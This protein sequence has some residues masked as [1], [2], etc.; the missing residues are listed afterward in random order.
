MYSSLL[1]S[2]F[3]LE[4]RETAL[5]TL[6]RHPRSHQLFNFEAY[7]KVLLFAPQLNVHAIQS[8]NTGY[9]PLHAAVVLGCVL[10]KKANVKHRSYRHIQMCCQA[11]VSLSERGANLFAPVVLDI[12]PNDVKGTFVQPSD[13]EEV[14]RNWEGASALHIAASCPSPYLAMAIGE[15]E[16]CISLLLFSLL[17]PLA[18]IVSEIKR[19]SPSM[20]EELFTAKDRNGRIPISVCSA[21]GCAATAGWLCTQAPGKYQLDFTDDTSTPLP[22]LV[23]RKGYRPEYVL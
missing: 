18:T 11:I 6:S 8:F 14:S 12:N 22:W 19:R 2:F 9:L 1:F 13:I 4:T 23:T 5:G 21:N 10:Y 3:S 20:L 17:S 7:A 15:S 16:C